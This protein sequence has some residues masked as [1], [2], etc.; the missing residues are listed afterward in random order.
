V[1]PCPAPSTSAASGRRRRTRHAARPGS[2]QPGPYA[3]YLLRTARESLLGSKAVT[4][5]K[6]VSSGSNHCLAALPRHCLA[7]QQSL[8]PRYRSP[9]QVRRSEP[10]FS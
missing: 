5:S 9:P 10:V 2:T 3:R 7:A 4:G 6:A 1:R 8:T